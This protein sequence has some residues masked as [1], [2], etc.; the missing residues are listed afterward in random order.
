MLQDCLNGMAGERGFP[1][2]RSLA[3]PLVVMGAPG[4]I[5]MMLNSML[6]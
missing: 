1:V 3:Q 2:V 6:K 5:A 4:S